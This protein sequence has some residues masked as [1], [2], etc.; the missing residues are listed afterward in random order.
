MMV[1]R[2]YSDAS[3]PAPTL[4]TRY[5]GKV[6]PYAHATDCAGRKTEMT[7]EKT[8]AQYSARVVGAF[9]PTPSMPSKPVVIPTRTQHHGRRKSNIQSTAEQHSLGNIRGEHD[10]AALS[11][12]MS[13]LLAMTSIPTPKRSSP[14]IGQKRVLG[15]KHDARRNTVADTTRHTLSSSN[16]HTWDF[17]LSPPNVDGT[18]SESFSSD[19]TI[20][21][22]SS[23]RSFSSDSMP[24]LEEDEESLCSASDPATPAIMANSRG[25][26]KKS[27]STSKGKDCIMDH[28]LLPRP[29]RRPNEEISEQSESE[30][31]I[32][33]HRPAA[34]RSRT[35]FKSNLTASF[36]AVRSAARS[37][38]DWTMSSPQIDQGD[39]L[40]RSLLSLTLPY[41]VERRPL[42]L[43][44]PPNPALRRYLNP[45]MLSPTELHFHEK[46]SE[47]DVKACIQLETYQRG[48]RPSQH[49]S[50]P[51]IFPS[52]R[53]PWRKDAL[54]TED[55]LTSSLLPRQREPRENSD[56]LRVIVLEMNMRKVGKLP[57]ANPGRAKLW[58]PAR[59]ID[60]SR[61]AAVEDEER[62]NTEALAVKGGIATAGGGAKPTYSKK[63]P[64]RWVGVTVM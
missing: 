51:P 40:T 6:L 44:E 7:V 21:P 60:N 27:L 18:E 26:R 11:P 1:P 42:P 24:S 50:S 39:N 61:L 17:L 59:Q 32:P 57:G 19:T 9:S 41:T 46:P 29:M 53:Q 43:N 36:R 54:D 16:P 45:M 2:S 8:K 31:P 52:K 23:V 10:Q 5:T 4:K 37:F 56:F 33:E 35:S 13:A 47:V 12:S 3:P 55:P 14:S 58:L 62:Q 63:V 15:V 64:A 22:L 34:V 20:G 25:E 48:N 30:L 49:A 38:S 28:P